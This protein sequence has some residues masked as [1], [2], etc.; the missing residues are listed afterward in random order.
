ML[1]SYEYKSSP[2]AHPFFS[3]SLASILFVLVL[4]YPTEYHNNTVYCNRHHLYSHP[5]I[6]AMKT[7]KACVHVLALVGFA[8]V[9]ISS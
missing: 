5:A 7:L 2:L 4:P 1:L 6:R 9:C 8:V 3:T